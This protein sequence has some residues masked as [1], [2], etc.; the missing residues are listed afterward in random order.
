LDVRGQRADDA[1]E[2]LDAF[3]DKLLRDGHGT[4]H[5][6]HGHGGGALKKAIRQHLGRSRY[7]LRH[8]PGGSDDGGDAWTIIDLDPRARAG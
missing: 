3:L 2:L 5:V 1:I 7:V 8:A 4:G 6:L